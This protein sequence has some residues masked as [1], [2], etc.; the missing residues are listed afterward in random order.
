V[1]QFLFAPSATLCAFAR[2]DLSFGDISRKGAKAYL[3]RKE[4]QI[5]TLQTLGDVRVAAFMTRVVP[6][7]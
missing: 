1:F 7:A 5:K 4:N 6:S 2:N 3:S